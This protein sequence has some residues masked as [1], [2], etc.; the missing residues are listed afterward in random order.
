MQYY[1]SYIIYINYIINASI[2]QLNLIKT[3]VFTVI[4]D[5]YD[6]RFM[7]VQKDVL[8]KLLTVF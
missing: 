4:Y 7:R 1:T 2:Q 3:I 5:Y 8:R 6:S